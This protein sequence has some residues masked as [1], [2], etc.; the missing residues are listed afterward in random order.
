V[1][2]VE[3]VLEGWLS[4]GVCDCEWCAWG[5]FCF[6]VVGCCFGVSLWMGV[7]GDGVGGWIRFVWGGGGLSGMG[8]VLWVLHVGAVFAVGTGIGVVLWVWC[9]GGVWA[10]V[11][12]WYGWVWG[13]VMGYREGLSFGTWYG[14]GGSC[15]GGE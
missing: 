11:F 6:L 15:C 9:G 3:F 4:W 12:E 13:M 7:I 10:W 2:G 14:T 1:G 5:V 8:H